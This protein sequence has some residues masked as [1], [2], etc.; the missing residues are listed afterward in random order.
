MRL[1]P[2]NSI[3]LADQIHQIQHS[4]FKIQNLTHPTHNIQLTTHNIQNTFTDLN[5]AAAFFPI[6]R[7]RLR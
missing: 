4:T 5:P 1:Q 6:L 7:F 3:I 2:I